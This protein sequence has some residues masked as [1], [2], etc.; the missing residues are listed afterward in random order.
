M[1]YRALPLLMAVTFVPSGAAQGQY[2]NVYHNDW[3]RWMCVEICESRAELQGGSGGSGCCVAHEPSGTCEWYNGGTV[4]ASMN[5]PGQVAYACVSSPDGG[6]H[7]ADQKWNKG[8]TGTPEQ[9]LQDAPAPQRARITTDGY[10]LEW[11][12]EFSPAD[13]P[14][15]FPNTTYWGYE[16]ADE[17]RQGR[18]QWY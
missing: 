17:I 4:D 9:A 18:L 12:D 2:P 11:A 5:A 1:G 6:G 3:A 10:K 16:G 7:C 15:G 13:C 14:G 8:C